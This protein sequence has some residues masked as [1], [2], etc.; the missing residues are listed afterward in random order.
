M[1]HF[2]YFGILNLFFIPLAIYFLW[3]SNDKFSLVKLPLSYVGTTH[4]KRQFIFLVSLG[5]LIELLFVLHILSTVDMISNNIL[6]ALL[7]VGFL[8]MF[9]TAATPH[10][11]PR[12]HKAGITIMVVA[13]TLWSFYFHYALSTYSS[14]V[15]SIGFILSILTLTGVPYLYF[16]IK[17]KGLTELFFIAV[18][19][20]WNIL[21]TS[22]IL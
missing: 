9:L 21:M 12:L 15:A 13:M 14:V 6:L 1:E 22:H 18:V 8:G 4:S 2:W 7:V 17:S 5:T 16:Y 19:L 10:S 11:K 3:V 20:F